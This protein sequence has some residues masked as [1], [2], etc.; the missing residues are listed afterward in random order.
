MPVYNRTDELR[1]ALDSLVAQTFKDFECLVIDDCSTVDIAS[2]VGDYDE[3][4]RYLKTPANGGPSAARMVGF[5]AM[6]GELMFR[7]DS[8]NE[9]YPWA[10]DRAAAFLDATPEAS[11]V[12]GSY[13]F[14]DGLRT[15]VRNDTRLITP[16]DFAKGN[17][18]PH[19]QVGVVRKS[20]IDEWLCKSRDYYS[21][22][23]HQWFTYAMK[24][25]HL[26]VDEPWGKYNEGTGPRVS[27]SSDERHY[28]DLSL[29]VDEHR[30]VYGSTPCVPLDEYLG[31]QWVRLRRAGRPELGKVESWMH[32]RG[33]S[34]RK[35]LAR[36]LKMKAA[37]SRSTFYL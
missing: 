33:L 32:E 35:A 20:V 27:T 17:R 16:A 15:R 4:F 28:A 7:L 36:R 25:N 26:V 5:E 21:A 19:D 9:L 10:M 12:A 14:P 24:H 8:D 37:R 23:F 3:R 31:D 6:Q 30:E 1:R 11:G 2:V 13:V 22:E 29:F 34:R 18:S